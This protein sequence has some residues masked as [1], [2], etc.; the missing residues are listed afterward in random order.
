MEWTS[1]RFFSR[2][3][4]AYSPRQIAMNR[5]PAMLLAVGLTAALVSTTQAQTLRNFI[6]TAP[7]NNWYTPAN[8]DSGFVPSK[9]ADEVGIV[10]DNHTTYVD[11]PMA[12]TTFD[13][14]SA[15]PGEVRVGVNV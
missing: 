5:Y 11:A 9:D 7:N 8:W 13:G 6:G 1:Y 15:N 4:L 10:N 2:K 3:H 14:F 12:D